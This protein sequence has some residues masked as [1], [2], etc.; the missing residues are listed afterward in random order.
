M[1]RRMLSIVCSAVA[2]VSIA[3]GGGC[4][5]SS[6][7]SALSDAASSQ[8]IGAAGG[9]VTLPDG[10]GV[11][12]P[13]GALP[14]GTTI[15]VTVQADPSAP[16]V[17][18]SLGTSVGAI[19][20][21]QPE[22]QQFLKPVTIT[23]AF[24]PSQIPAD[25]STADIVD[26]TSPGGT[27]SY[28]SLPTTRVDASHVAAQTTHFSGHGAGLP[29]VSDGGANDG[30][31][32]ASVDAT[33]DAGEDTTADVMSDGG[34]PSDGSGDA[35]GPD[36]DAGVCNCVALPS[37]TATLTCADAGSLPSF[38][39]GT[40]V[41]G[42]YVETE[43][44]ST[45]GPDP[46]EGTAC[47]TFGPN[48]MT[49][50]VSGSSWQMGGAAAP[51]EQGSMTATW[52]AVASTS[53]SDLSLTFSCAS[54]LQTVP[55]SGVE[56]YQYTATPTGLELGG[57]NGVFIL[58]LQPTDGGTGGYPDAPSDAAS[59]AGPGDGSASDASFACAQPA[60]PAT[61]V[62]DIASCASP[63]TPAGGTIAD[64]TYYLTSAIAYATDAGCPTLTG[65]SQGT[66]VVSGGEVSTVVV[67]GENP[68]GP[69]GW[70]LSTVPT[71]GNLFGSTCI[72][73]TFSNCGDA[74]GS[75][76]ATYTATASTLLVF[77]SPNGVFTFT[78][79]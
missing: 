56:T 7:G 47:G 29:A 58:A 68:P 37:V 16:S 35:C 15:D 32:E 60:D 10:T 17:P 30:G 75:Q 46:S 54:A 45:M 63:P 20:L 67:N 25:R 1:L 40:I 18:A 9:S 66:I 52:S 48:R 59:D 31:P 49:V 44:I 34:P 39:G 6:G 23:L 76:P 26:F 28:A 8:Q 3:A 51:P 62:L 78:Q 41:D 53:G 24:D 77:P 64:G 61:P 22:G 36:P 21:F 11:T 27:P 70:E 38:Q 2:G 43:M 69:P 55:D 12:I 65:H 4:S 14:T 79:Q 50:V 33:V 19:Y 71:A 72:C 57:P 73:G 42:R 74:G 13:A 5:S